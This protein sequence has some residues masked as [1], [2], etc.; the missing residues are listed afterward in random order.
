MGEKEGERLPKA[1]VDG[2]V[3]RI[4]WAGSWRSE[5]ESA[6]SHRSASR[7][8]RRFRSLST[9]PRGHSQYLLFQNSPLSVL[10]LLSDQTKT[11]LFSSL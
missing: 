1:Q 6:F 2:I 11:L 10:L 7:T 9:S 8:L 5:T 4:G 3:R